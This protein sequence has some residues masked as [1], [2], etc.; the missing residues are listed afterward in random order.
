MKQIPNILLFFCF[1]VLNIG[2]K[3]DMIPEVDED[4]MIE[5][6]NPIGGSRLGPNSAINI[7]ILAND[8]VAGILS[9]Q[10]LSYIVKEGECTYFHREVVCESKSY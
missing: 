10:T 4:L 3:D 1:P 6:Y 7:T 5:L 2:I 9:F 8:H